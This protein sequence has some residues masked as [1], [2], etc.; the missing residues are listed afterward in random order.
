MKVRTKIALPPEVEEKLHRAKRVELVSLM[1]MISCV[2]VIWLTLGQSQAMKAIWVE[3][4]LAVIPPAAYLISARVRWREPN[5]RFPYG[6]QHSVTIG[7]LT[8]AIVLVAL[9]FIIFIDSAM[10]LLEKSHPVI[11]VVGIFGRQIWLGW[12]MLPALVYTICCEYGVSLF[13]GKL[14]ED[15]HD[16]TL[17]ADA[18]MNRA[19]WLAGASGIIGVL[20]IT[21]GIWWLDSAAALVISAEVIRDG[22]DNLKGAVADIMDEVP[23]SA[24]QD[25]SADDQWAAKLRAKVKSLGWVRDADV[26]LREEGNL[27]TGEV[28]VIPRSTDDV[29][30][31][32]SEVNDLARELDWRFYDLSL[33]MTDE[34]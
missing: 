10:K 25:E 28:Y 5:E 30:K 9:G 33:V 4:L 21:F 31:R 34:L 11:G 22:I 26:R 24:G 13:K 18:R 17:A 14:A 12:L 15:L 32:W 16:T 3:D 20:G 23:E 7:F 6:Y 27:F 29:T 2:V 1:F 8:T 19:D